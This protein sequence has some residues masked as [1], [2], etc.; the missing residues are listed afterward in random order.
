MAMIR[1]TPEELRG[2][3]QAVITM[4]ENIREILSN[5]ETQI[6]TICDS[7]D[8]MAQDAFLASY[9]SMK[10]TLQQFPDIVDGMGQQTIAAADAFEE[11]DSAISS[12]FSG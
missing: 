8:G 2:Q 10:S 1:V 4:A 9:E 5:L 11:T 3:G 6:N 12:A 7:W